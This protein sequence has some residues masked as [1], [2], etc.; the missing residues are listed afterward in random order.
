MGFTSTLNVFDCYLCPTM[1]ALNHGLPIL[2]K[3]AQYNL[4]NHYI[5][6]FIHLQNKGVHEDGKVCKAVTSVLLVSGDTVARYGYL[7]AVE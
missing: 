2:H 3:P 4:Y 5:G 6:S 1:L 7:A